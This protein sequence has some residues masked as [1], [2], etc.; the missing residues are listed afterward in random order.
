[1]TLLPP[2]PRLALGAFILLAATSGQS[3]TLGR[4]QGVALIGRPLDVGVQVGL[5]AGADAAALCIDAEVFYADN[6]IDAGRVTTRVESSSGSTATV[7]VRSTAAVDE[8]VVTVY[9]RVGCSQ[10]VTRRYVLL[11]EQP[12]ELPQQSAVPLPAAEVPSAAPAP[13]APARPARTGVAAPAAAAGDRSA[14]A[15]PSGAEA[16]A[17]RTQA[18]EDA[19]AARAAARAEAAAAVKPAAARSGARLKLEPL[20]LASER[21]PSLR[22]SSSMAAAPEASPQRRAEAMALWQALNAQPEDILRNM[23]RIQTL[24]GDVKSLRDGVQKNNA[25]LAALRTELEKAQGQRHM[26]FVVYGLLALLLVAAALAAFFALRRRRPGA[27]SDGDWWRGGSAAGESEFG[28]RP[29]APKEPVQGPPSKAVDLDLSFTESVIDHLRESPLTA[30]GWPVSKS[31][32]GRG[33][34]MDFA[35]SQV[36]SLRSVKAEELHDIQQQADFFVSLGEHDQA[37]EVLRSHINSHPETSVV[38]WLDLL[39]IYHK[40]Q[41]REDYE[42][43]RQEFHSVFNAQ[44]PSFEAYREQTEGLQAYHAALSR[45]VALWP[46]PKVLDVIEES[47]F[48]KP[49]QEG[50]DAFGLEAYRELLMLYH[51][52]KD[53]IEAGDSLA[54]FGPSSGSRPDFSHT[55][56]HPLSASIA[57]S[58]RKYADDE[59]A[60]A[61]DF[62]RIG[63]DINLDEPAPPSAELAEI[64]SADPTGDWH[65]SNMVDFDLPDIDL[66][67]EPK[68][69]RS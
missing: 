18:R 42:S 40:L 5:D 38:A 67:P 20:D 47:I 37:I 4:S 14:G 43:T 30:S 66:P 17:A 35:A 3:L 34:S 55:S 21:D 8:P 62:P 25:G 1:M 41:R 58:R 16:R 26:N 49:G 45:I 22:A 48:R 32:G 63:L 6:R 15:K 65:H 68:L 59:D 12:G 31:P 11:A 9:M 33:D 27:N 51:I 64:G 50:S 39:E 28:M 10:R 7:R 13:A 60:T 52:G 29:P 36:E 57:A 56:I 46:S 61:V 53:V 23:Q 19:R 69:P 24:E 44:V 54:D 2:F